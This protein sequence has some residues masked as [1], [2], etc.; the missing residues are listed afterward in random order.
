MW[1][2]FIDSCMTQIIAL[3]NP[4]VGVIAAEGRL[5][6]DGTKV[7]TDHLQKIRPLNSHL[8]LAS[9]GKW[10]SDTVSFNT[11]L[12]EIE[13]ETPSNQTH[14]QHVQ[15]IANKMKSMWPAPDTGC[16]S[17]GYDPVIGVSGLQIMEGLHRPIGN[18]FNTGYALNAD[19]IEH[20]QKILKILDEVFRVHFSSTYTDY[21]FYR[22]QLTAERMRFILKTTIEKVYSD[23]VL[24]A[25]N[26]IGPRI[27][28]LKVTKRGWQW[29][30][31]INQPF[32]TKL[33]AL[34]WEKDKGN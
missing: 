16:I 25:D 10:G 17:L 27:D 4:Q 18:Q 11:F 22:E 19:G 7:L 26:K 3:C 12:D 13:K 30:E 28:I 2:F 6:E 5:V 34:K 29:M 33:D 20:G 1:E 31:C 21:K 15:Y 24:N 23:P 14:L 8:V 32:R 9:H